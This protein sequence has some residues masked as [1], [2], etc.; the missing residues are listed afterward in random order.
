VDETRAISDAIVKLPH[1]WKRESLPSDRIRE[2]SPQNPVQAF[3]Y[4]KL[5]SSRR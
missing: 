4:N 2:A 5:H 3:P 1:A